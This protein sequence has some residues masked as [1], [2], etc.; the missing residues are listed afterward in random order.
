MTI[1]EKID[2]LTDVL[3]KYQSHIADI[4]RELCTSEPHQ[5]NSVLAELREAQ[6][7]RADLESLIAELA[8]AL[9]AEEA[10]RTTMPKG[11]QC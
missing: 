7:T 9:H 2:R 8:V 6:E 3:R 4:E 10:V 5:V 11:A 1:R